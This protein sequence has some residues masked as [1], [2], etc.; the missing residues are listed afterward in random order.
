MKAFTAAYARISRKPRTTS[1]P[2][3]DT[4]QV[5]AIGRFALTYVNPHAGCCSRSPPHR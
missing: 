2:R 5:H 4:I 3:G 1:W